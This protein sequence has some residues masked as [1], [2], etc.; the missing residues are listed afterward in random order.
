MNIS[1]DMEVLK[2]ELNE[3]MR[4]RWAG[5]WEQVKVGVAGWQK[6]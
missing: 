3:E 5:D 6:L 4:N 2:T 1:L